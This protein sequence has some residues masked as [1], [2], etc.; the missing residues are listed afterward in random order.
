MLKDID[1]LGPASHGGHCV[2]VVMVG[3]QQLSNPRSLMYSIHYMPAKMTRK[4][5]LGHCGSQIGQAEV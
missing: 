4:G 2:R 5:A 1:V 3:S